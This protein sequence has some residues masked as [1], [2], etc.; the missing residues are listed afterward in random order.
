M[1]NVLNLQSS[2][3]GDQ[4]QS[5]QLAAHYIDDLRK[6]HDDIQVVNRSLDADSIP[7]L[8]LERFQALIAKPEQRSAAQQAVVDFSDTLIAEL[9][10]ADVIVLAVP[11]YNFN[12]PAA[13]HN[14]FDHVT[15]AGVTFRYTQEGPVGFLKGKHVAAF[16]TRGGLYGEAHSHGAFL[17]QIL[18]FIGLDEVEYFHAEGLA[19]SDESRAKSLTAARHDIAKAT[20][21]LA[22]V[23]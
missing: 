3:F 11:M 1:T 21:P 17:Q 8:T 19:I 6:K 2:L 18:S 22:G 23:A 15:R 9:E 13:L 10:A 20:R 14:Y 4:G 7:A 16:I 5:S 12:V